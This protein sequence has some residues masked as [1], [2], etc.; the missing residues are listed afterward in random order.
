[1]LQPETRYT[2]VGNDRI[3]YQILGEGPR[4]L[5]ATPGQWG[6]VDLDWEEPAAARFYRRLASFSRLIRFDPRG[7]GLSDPR[8]GDGRGTP[9]P[10]PTRAGIRPAAQ[11][12][13][14]VA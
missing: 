2:T 4:D 13:R 5:V 8:P 10:R 1:M 7:S 3:A 9:S 12:P 6:H 14:G 11:P